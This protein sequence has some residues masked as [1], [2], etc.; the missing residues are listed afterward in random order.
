MGEGGESGGVAV[1]MKSGSRGWWRRK[2]AEWERKEEDEREEV[3]SRGRKGRWIESQEEREA[4]RTVQWKRR[5]R[6][7]RPKRLCLCRR[8]RGT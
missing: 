5:V 4:Q 6:K 3:S 1:E 7:A 8:C 2:E